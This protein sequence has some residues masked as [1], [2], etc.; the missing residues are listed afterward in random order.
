MSVPTNSAME[1]KFK[2]VQGD[3]QNLLQNIN[4]MHVSKKEFTNELT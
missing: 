2:Q 1:I 4:K 3:L